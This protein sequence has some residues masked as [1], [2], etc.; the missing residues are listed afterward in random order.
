MSN[1]DIVASSVPGSCTLRND[2]DGSS[3]VCLT[4]S[5]QLKAGSDIATPI[6]VVFMLDE[7]IM[8]RNLNPAQMENSGP[9]SLNYYPDFTV[10]EWKN[11]TA[12][13]MLA[14]IKLSSNDSSAFLRIA[15][16][17]NIIFSNHRCLYDC[18]TFI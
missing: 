2:S 10:D 8:V 12:T 11:G 17:R 1:T 15:V 5:I 6:P 13:W 14:G 7:N 4:P 3:M 18:L 9:A 16:S